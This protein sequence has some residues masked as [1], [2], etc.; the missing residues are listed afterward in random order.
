MIE[1]MYTVAELAALTKTHKSWWYQ[2]LNGGRCPIPHIKLGT[3]FVRFRESDVKQYLDRQLETAKTQADSR[4][5][6]KAV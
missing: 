5:R 2:Q 1:P 3:H 6:L 4:R